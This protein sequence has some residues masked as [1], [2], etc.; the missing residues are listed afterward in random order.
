M[1]QKSILKTRKEGQT[2]KVNRKVTIDIHDQEERAR[3]NQYSKMKSYSRQVFSSSS[4]EN[5]GFELFQ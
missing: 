3:K 1:A 5:I 4:K 2:V